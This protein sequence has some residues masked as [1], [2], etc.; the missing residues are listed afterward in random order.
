MSSRSGHPKGLRAAVSRG[1]R[2]VPGCE[3]T[4]PIYCNNE[5][6]PFAR[7]ESGMNETLIVGAGPVGLIMAAE[8]ARYRTPVRIIDRAPQATTTSKALVLWSRTLEL[9]DRMGCTQVFLGPGLRCRAGTIRS[10]KTVL[11]HA[12]FDDVDSPY[13]FALMIP[14]CDTERLMGGASR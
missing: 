12:R 13:N 8:L 4:L 1:G 9:M 2:A 6:C 7:S 10:G 3:R 14:Q 11:G 5:R